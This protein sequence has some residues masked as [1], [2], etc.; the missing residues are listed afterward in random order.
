MNEEWGGC[1]PL[2]KIRP[3]GW[4]SNGRH[5]G[6]GGGGGG[7]GGVGLVSGNKIM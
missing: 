6:G 3:C 5:W 1:L 2:M 7:G 4:I